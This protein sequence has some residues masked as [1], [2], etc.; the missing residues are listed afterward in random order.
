[1]TN[2][3]KAQSLAG[4]MAS[5]HDAGDCLIEVLHA[6]QQLYGYLDPGV[7]RFIAHRLR[8][9]PSRVL[10]AATFYH[11][12]RFAPA[13]PHSVLVCQG[14]A[15]Y[16]AG[17]EQLASIV[18]G[19]PGWKLRTGRCIGS[20]GVAPLVVCDG[21]TLSRVTPARLESQLSIRA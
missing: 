18:T 15:C 20:C 3:E 13:E 12:F 4:V 1:M 9:P 7:L 19:R 11:L 10:G 6:A 8:L 16:V 14:T 17:A 2:D 21:A 5:C